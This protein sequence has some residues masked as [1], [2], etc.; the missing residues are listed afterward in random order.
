MKLGVIGL[1]RSGKATVFEA[2]IQGAVGKGHKGDFRI[3]TVQVPDERVDVL[4]SI[5]K[6]QKST[7]AQ[8]ELCLPQRPASA[9]TE[10]GYMSQIRECDALV[11]VVRNFGGYG[12]ETPHPARDFHTLSQEL[13][14]ADLVVVENR[15]ERI[16]LDQKRGKKPDQTEARLLDECRQHLEAERALS[17]NPNLALAPQLRGFAFV[18]AK[19]IL[20][21]FN[22]EDEDEALPS[23]ET[24][25]DHEE[26]MV[27]RGKLEQ[28]LAQMEAEEA[29]EF[30]SEFNIAASAMDR[31]IRKSYEVLGQISFFTVVSEEVRVWTIK[32]GTEAL[33]AAGTVHTDMQKGFI[34]AE[35][36]AYSDLIRAGNYQEAKK[37][38]AVR[39]EGKDYMVR[40]GDIANFRFNI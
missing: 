31:V 34:R 3:A 4:K 39:L 6:P 10:T 1:P 35:V 15:L 28:E 21:L 30:L 12:F 20:V 19:P 38:G 18:S 23:I 24:I 8:M 7:F 9:K 11:H 29:R 26:C 14:L 27:I 33:E 13:I 16:A 17:K 40:D 36:I 5:Y 32:K 22:N 25:V 37:R 2:L